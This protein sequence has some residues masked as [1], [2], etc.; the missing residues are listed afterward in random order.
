MDWCRKHD[1]AKAERVARL[2]QSI[3][4]EHPGGIGKPE[5][6][7]GNLSGHWSRRVDSKNRLVYRIEDGVLVVIQ[8]R[9]HY[10][11]A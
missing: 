10:T 8:A 3:Q 7:V 4:A 11:D 5:A 6:L 1:K 2:L 9:R